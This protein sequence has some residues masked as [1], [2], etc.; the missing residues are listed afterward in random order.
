MAIQY[1][2]PKTMTECYTN[3][4]RLVLSY[5]KAHMSYP[6]VRED[7]REDL[8]QDFWLMA[9]RLDLVGKFWAKA[10]AAGV[11]VSDLPVL[12]R[13][14]LKRAAI[15]F[16][17]NYLRDQSRKFNLNACLEAPLTSDRVAPPSG[18]PHT[19]SAV[20]ADRQ[21]PEVLLSA[22]REF[23]RQERAVA[24]ARAMEERGLPRL[25]VLEFFNRQQVPTSTG[26]HWCH[27]TLN[28]VL[29]ERADLSVATVIQHVRQLAG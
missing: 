8:V 4:H 17:T 6:R 29:D 25:R 21:T 9:S 16:L 22:K 1:P 13:G 14:Y 10:E 19:A 5:L 24:M 15:G 26:G 20:L 7:Y 23:L 27:Q 12:F 28:R 2:A 11:P 18:A 3:Y